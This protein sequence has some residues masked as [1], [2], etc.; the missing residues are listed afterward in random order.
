MARTKK[1]LVSFIPFSKG[2]EHD[3]VTHKFETAASPGTFSFWLHVHLSFHGT[4]NKLE[5]VEIEF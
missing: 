3:R 5:W 1:Y 4:T 2:K